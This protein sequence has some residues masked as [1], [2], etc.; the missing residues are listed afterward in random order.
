MT[1]QT[2]FVGKR[3]VAEGEP[4]GAGH[5]KLWLLLGVA[6]VAGLRLQFFFDL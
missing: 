4:V 6:L 2:V 3:I 5:V 1:S